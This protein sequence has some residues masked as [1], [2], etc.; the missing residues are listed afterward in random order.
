MRHVVAF[1]PQVSSLGP[2]PSQG[3]QARES[4]SEQQLRTK[5]ESQSKHQSHLHREKKM[6]KR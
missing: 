2:D 3:Y 5:S 6:V 1:R 4:P